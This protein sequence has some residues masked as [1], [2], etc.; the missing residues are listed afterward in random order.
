MEELWPEIR[1]KD[2][3]ECQDNKQN[4]SSSNFGAFRILIF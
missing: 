3:L 2:E 4:G 1:K